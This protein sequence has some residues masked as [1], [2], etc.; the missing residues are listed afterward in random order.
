M[1]RSR[2]S[3][4]FTTTNADVG[5]RHFEA[6][7]HDGKG[8]IVRAE[9]KLTAFVELESTIRENTVDIVV[10]GVG[11]KRPRASG[12]VELASGVAPQREEPDRR[13]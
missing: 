11:K 3:I 9:E 13:V 5:T 2:R 10:C 6:H 1:S 4:S 12:R 7:R 8:F